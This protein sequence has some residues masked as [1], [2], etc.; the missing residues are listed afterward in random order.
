MKNLFVLAAIL[1]LSFPSFANDVD[2][3]EDKN[4]EEANVITHKIQKDLVD[5]PSCDN[6]RLVNEVKS[7]ITDFFEKNKSYNVLT[8]RRKHFILSNLSSF[9]QE[10]IANYNTSETVHVAGVVTN[11]FMNENIL[12]ENMRLC[13]SNDNNNI[14]D[15][16]ILLY[17][18]EEGY[19]VVLLNL[20]PKQSTSSNISFVYK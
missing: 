13:K 8:R 6:E 18:V 10:N 4:I 2:V 20:I 19:K 17:P 14:D 12:K 16:F 15:F 11:L 9:K 3:V 5:M 7:F 1:M